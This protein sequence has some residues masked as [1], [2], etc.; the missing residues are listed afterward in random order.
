[1]MFF[2]W[3]DVGTRAFR[4]GLSLLWGFWTGKK[5]GAWPCWI[6]FNQKHNRIQ[7][8]YTYI[9]M[10]CFFWAFRENAKKWL[11]QEI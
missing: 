7:G 1:M 2:L 11:F 6:G 8:S 9:L 3:E 4:L 10:V 5:K